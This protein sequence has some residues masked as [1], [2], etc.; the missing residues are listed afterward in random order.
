MHLYREI[1]GLDIKQLMAYVNKTILLGIE[2]A[3]YKNI[4]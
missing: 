2:I 3:V 1:I 4:M